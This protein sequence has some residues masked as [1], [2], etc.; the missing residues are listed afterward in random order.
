MVQERT[1]S[2]VVGSRQRSQIPANA[3]TGEPSVAVKRCG[4]R[5][6]FGP[7]H[8]KKPLAGMM[9]R[10]SALVDGIRTSSR[11]HPVQ[12]HHADGSLSVLSSEAAGSQTR[13][14]SVL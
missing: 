5:A 7:V 10:R 4:W 3:S 13:P 8:S 6:V 2:L 9:Q 12:H 11:Q 14:I 1:S